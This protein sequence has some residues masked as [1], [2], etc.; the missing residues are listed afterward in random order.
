MQDRLDAI[1]EKIEGELLNRGFEKKAIYQHSNEI[2]HKS[3]FEFLIDR[4]LDGLDEMTS[5]ETWEYMKKITNKL[6]AELFMAAEE[7]RK[8]E[9]EVRHLKNDY[10]EI[11]KE[12]K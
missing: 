2:P 4:R 10:Q 6:Q 11:L 1:I 8:K 7:Y 9:N 12:N 3:Y 5:Q